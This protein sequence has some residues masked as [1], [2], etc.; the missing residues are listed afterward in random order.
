M[1]RWDLIA[2]AF[3]SCVATALLTGCGGSQ[4]PIGAPDATSQR[5]VPAFNV[6]RGHRA[7]SAYRVLHQFDRRDGGRAP[8]AQLVDVKG[9]LYGTTTTGGKSK[10]GTVYSISPS[11]IEKTLYE[12]RGGSEDGSRPSGRLLDVN[13]TLYGTTGSGGSKAAGTV[14]TISITGKERVIYSFSGGADGGNP[15]GGLIDVK[16]ALYGTTHAGGAQGEGTVYTMSTTGSEKV[17][18]SFPD[19]VYDGHYPVGGVIAV[20]GTLY[21]TTWEGGANDVGTVYSVTPAGVEKVLYDDFGSPRDGSSPLSGL[22]YVNGTLY[23]TTPIG[24]ICCG[25]VYA[26]TMIGTERVVYDFGGA[27]RNDGSQPYAG[28]IDMNGTLYGTTPIGG[29]LDEPPLCGN[30]GQSGCGTVFSVTTSGREKVLHDFT[31]GADGSSPLAALLAVNGTLYGT[32]EHAQRRKPEG[33]GT[34]FAL[35]P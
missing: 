29:D 24:G 21:G 12:F 17:L 10:S 19:S 34:V 16:G 27:S 20:K 30:S 25:T 13:G 32:T 23:G 5:S 3:T 9:T 4:L 26:V 2:Y 22:V 35:T 1:I 28:L 6:M 31:G 8:V 14:Y 15:G 18:H 7:S 33:P 11:G